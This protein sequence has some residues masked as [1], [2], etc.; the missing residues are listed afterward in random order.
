MGATEDSR[1]KSAYNETLTVAFLLSAA[2]LLCVLSYLKVRF[3]GIHDRT[4]EPVRTGL[5]PSDV[6]SADSLC[7][8]TRSAKTKLIMF[9][10]YECPPCRSEWPKVEWF[11]LEHQTALAVYFRYYPLVKIHP[12]AMQAAVAAEIAKQKGKFAAMHKRLYSSALNRDA[13]DKDFREVGLRP[14]RDKS[15]ELSAAH[16]V[17]DD[18]NLAMSLGLKGTPSFLLVD[19]AGTVYSLSSLDSARQFFN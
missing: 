12:N 8:G 14:T 13:I 3:P 17:V 18:L 10:D 19:K 4:A 7:L 6:V 9:G 1:R 16:R 15:L 5:D 11:A 2:S